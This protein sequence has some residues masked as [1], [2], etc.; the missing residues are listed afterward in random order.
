MIRL[1]SK[2]QFCINQLKAQ[3]S[4]KAYWFQQSKLGPVDGRIVGYGIGNE[5]ERI[6]SSDF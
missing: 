5:S 1:E 2:Q 6:K 4:E 3:I